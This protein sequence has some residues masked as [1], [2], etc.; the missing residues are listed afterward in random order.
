M[1][2]L[3]VQ[4]ALLFRF[5]LIIPAFFAIFAPRLLFYGGRTNWRLVF[6]NIRQRERVNG[7]I[8]ALKLE[9]EL[10][11]LKTILPVVAVAGVL[12]C[13]PAVLLHAGTS[14]FASPEA[15]GWF[16]KKKKSETKDSVQSK[17]DYEKLTGSDAI[18]R[19]GMFNVYQKKSDY[20]FEVPARLLGRDMLVVN[21]LQR[22]PSELNEDRKSVV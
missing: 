5:R 13:E 16:R 22:V 2:L 10:M 8:V 9:F 7:V 4:D 11:K 20:Y 15:M 17:S 6:I 19:K 14:D 12:M 18:A 21:K 1:R 3:S